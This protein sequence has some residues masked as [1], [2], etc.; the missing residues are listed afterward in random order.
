MSPSDPIDALITN[1]DRFLAL[2]DRIDPEAWGRV[3]EGGG[4]SVAEIADHITVVE[5]KSGRFLSG[6]LL[7]QEAIT[8]S[9]ETTGKEDVIRGRM[10]DPTPRP[11]PD[12]VQPC[13][14]W[15]NPAEL[16]EAFAEA[17]NAT[18]ALGR[19][20]GAQL[21]VRVAPHP[22]FGPLTG[23]QWLFFLAEHCER[24]CGQME[25]MLGSQAVGGRR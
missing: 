6:P 23:T 22:A 10:A 5:R 17:R 7:E 3:P 4:W 21:S 13:G 16:G 18:I 24:H 11:A 20:H 9:E 15:S 8:S 2:L 25:R 12:I 14:K 1:R 19:S